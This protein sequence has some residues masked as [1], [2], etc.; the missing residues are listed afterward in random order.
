MSSALLDRY[1]L[2][3]KRYI[4]KFAGNH[5]GK[6]QV[7]VLSLD[8]SQLES[9]RVV[10]VVSSL[11]FLADRRR[12]RRRETVGRRASSRHSRE[13]PR[14]KG[15]DRWREGGRRPGG[16]IVLQNNL[17]FNYFGELQ[18]RRCDSLTVCHRK[19]NWL[20]PASQQPPGRS[21]CFD[22][23]RNSLV[24][25]SL[26]L[27]LSF[28]VSSSPFF[29]SPA[30]PFQPPVPNQLP[31]A[32]RGGRDR[33]VFPGEARRG[34]AFPS[35]IPMQLAVELSV[36][37]RLQ[38]TTCGYDRIRPNIRGCNSTVSRNSIAT[39]RRR[40]KPM[41]TRS[42]SSVF[43]FAALYF[44]TRACTPVCASTCTPLSSSILSERTVSTLFSRITKSAK[45][46][47]PIYARGNNR[48]RSRCGE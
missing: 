11:S 23:S 10:S 48:F 21:S 5:S 12:R 27:S 34:E 6:R 38:P 18:K 4:R 36:T 29:L 39:S 44:H 15:Q 13:K 17:N 7:D 26:S 24:H 20:P 45:V 22:H 9:D 19:I 41:K 1:I 16:V 33:T 28:S 3:Q 30:F 32:K 31:R 47:R 42:V 37:F 43:N 46:F 35:V 40:V 8:S 14:E 2:Y 25:D